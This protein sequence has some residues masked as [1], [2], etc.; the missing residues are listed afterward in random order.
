[1]INIVARYSG[2]VL[3]ASASAG[4]IAEAVIEAN[5]SRADLYGANLSGADLSGANLSGANLSRA[6]LYGADLSRADLSGANLSGANLSRADLYGA[7]LSR[8]DLYG[9][10]LSGA[11]LSG[12]NLSGA[13]L[14]RADLYGADLSGA[15]LYGANLYGANLSRA[16]LSGAAG[17]SAYASTPLMMLLDQTGKIRAYKLVDESSKGPTYPTITYALG[18]RVEALNAETDPQIQ[19][20]A[21]INVAT[22]DWCIREWKPGYRILV[23]EFEANDIA[24]IP[25]ATDGKFRLFRCDVVGEKDLHS[26]GIGDKQ[27]EPAAR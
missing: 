7:D 6:D 19:C 11:D 9:A 1:M 16:D 8:A 4:N 13:N 22:L 23:V 10:N 3:Y 25:I 17:I 27:T 26:I 2:A 18:E 5:L 14:S 20:A 15:D 24:A 12:A 21:G